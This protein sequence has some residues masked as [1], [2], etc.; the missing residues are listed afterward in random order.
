MEKEIIVIFFFYYSK[1]SFRNLK[2]KINCL[3]SWL[4]SYVRTWL[5]K[6]HIFEVKKKQQH[7]IV[8]LDKLNNT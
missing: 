5:F 4:N 2:Y 8:V 7:P 1:Q 3:W 6:L